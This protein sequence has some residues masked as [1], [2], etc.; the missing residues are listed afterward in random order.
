MNTSRRETLKKLA[1]GAAGV[2]LGS[3]GM[4]AKSYARILGANERINMSVIGVRGQGFGH[5]RRWAG[6][7]ENNNVF[8]RTICDVDENLFAEYE[9]KNWHAEHEKQGVSNN[10]INNNGR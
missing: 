6:M 7:A 5:L 1:A 3:M 9:I 10:S 8:V 4:T 2:T